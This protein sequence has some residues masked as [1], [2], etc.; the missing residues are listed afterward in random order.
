MVA[1]KSRLKIL[2][3]VLAVVLFIV[4]FVD[5][6]LAQQ[7]GS[8]FQATVTFAN[9]STATLQFKVPPV[10]VDPGNLSSTSLILEFGVDGSALP[11]DPGLSNSLTFTLKQGGQNVLPPFPINGL[12]SGQVVLDSTTQISMSQPNQRAAPGLYQLDIIHLQSFQAPQTWELDI[13]G[14]P[15]NVT[16]A[17][18]TIAALIGTHNGFT[19]LAPTGACQQSCPSVCPTGE[20]CQASTPPR[21]RGCGSGMHCCDTDENGNCTQCVPRNRFC[22]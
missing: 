18:R 15:A 12:P 8:R 7:S 16:P 17:I 6:A 22:E 21:P 4:S 19:A 1:Q 2:P 10:L 14:L 3:S 9:T 13:T 20:S 5:T 11:A